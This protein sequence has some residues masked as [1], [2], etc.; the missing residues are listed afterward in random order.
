MKQKK[1]KLVLILGLLIPLV[2]GVTSCKNP[3]EDENPPDEVNPME[4]TWVIAATLLR[5]DPNPSSIS[6]QGTA[7]EPLAGGST[8]WNMEFILGSASRSFDGWHG[9]LKV[10]DFTYHKQ[11]EGEYSYLINENNRTITLLIELRNIDDPNWHG[12][13][14]V[15]NVEEPKP[16]EHSILFSQNSFV[17]KNSG[18][19][20]YWTLAA[21]KKQG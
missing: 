19:T 12:T 1:M 7:G 8:I 6:I 2:M 15:E 20:S 5:A 9:T 11:L 13:L 14:R 21:Y 3:M 17:V 4:G 16:G 10:E 18:G